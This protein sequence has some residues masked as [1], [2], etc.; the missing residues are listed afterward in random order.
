MRDV[1]LS[2][3]PMFKESAYGL[4]CTTWEVSRSI[5][6]PYTRELV[7]V[8]P[9]GELFTAPKEKRTQEYVIGRFG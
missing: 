8:A 6:I 9:S 4:G 1:F 7:E 3:P 2:V 5:T